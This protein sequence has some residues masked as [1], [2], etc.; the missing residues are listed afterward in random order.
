MVW[1]KHFWL[2]HTPLAG[3]GEKL[4]I[5]PPC[6]TSPRGSPSWSRCHGEKSSVLLVTQGQGSRRQQKG[7]EPHIC[8]PGGG[9]N[10]TA[11]RLRWKTSERASE[12]EFE[13]RM[14]LRH[15]TKTGAGALSQCHLGTAML[16]K[17]M[18][19]F[20]GNCSLFSCMCFFTILFGN[21]SASMT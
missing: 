12:G 7:S 2:L 20:L 3:L 16:T 13:I 11:K 10:L 18:A 15:T 19:A 1:I 17:R 14:W 6:G 4:P 5:W 9:G 8:M 21:C